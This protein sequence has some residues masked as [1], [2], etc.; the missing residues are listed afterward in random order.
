MNTF[1]GF[2]TGMPMIVTDSAG[3][4][5]RVDEIL[6]GDRA[7]RCQI[8]PGFVQ[9]NISPPGSNSLNHKALTMR[10]GLALDWLQGAIRVVVTLGKAEIEP[11]HSI[12]KVEICDSG[13]SQEVD[14]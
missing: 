12:A 11:S 8:Y 13:P 9:L 1:H 14:L 3:V 7:R 2:C 4:D 10:E 5:W 6:S